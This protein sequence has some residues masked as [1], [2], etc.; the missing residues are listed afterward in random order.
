MGKKWL[1][2][3]ASRMST[4]RDILLSLGRAHVNAADTLSFIINNKYCAG[5][6]REYYSLSWH[7]LIFLFHSIR[8][9]YSMATSEMANIDI[10][11]RNFHMILGRR[12]TPWSP[13]PVGFAC[14]AMLKSSEADGRSSER[15]HCW[16]APTGDLVCARNG[17]VLRC[18]SSSYKY[19]SRE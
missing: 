1:Q 13:M 4:C 7:I 14:V 18:I 15:G 8:I 2:S 9:I 17:R 6:H 19:L 5:K 11:S 16:P 10:D 3:M 12:C